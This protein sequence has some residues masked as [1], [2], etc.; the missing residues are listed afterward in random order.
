MTTSTTTSLIG[1][2]HGAPPPFPTLLTAREVAR[3]LGVA[4]TALYGWLAQ[5]KLAHHR[6]G[7]VIRIHEGD[8]EAFLHRNR[9]EQ[10]E[11]PKRYG[12]YPQA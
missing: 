9:F 2:S 12:R 8:V 6:L 11:S 10:P 5:G 1:T 7:R 3:R 4:K